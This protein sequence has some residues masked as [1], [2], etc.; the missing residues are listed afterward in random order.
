MH[1][2]E[3]INLDALSDFVSIGAKLIYLKSR[4]LLP[5][6]L[7]EAEQAEE[8]AVGRELT[9]ML[10]EYKRFKGGGDGL[11]GR[12]KTKVSGLIAGRRRRLTCRCLRA[13]TK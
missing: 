11:C 1:S 2:W 12:L 4:A 7:T 8:E 6:L 3:H 5:L 9:E 13:S 10:R